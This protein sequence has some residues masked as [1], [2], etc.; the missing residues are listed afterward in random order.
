[1]IFMMNGNRTS[2]SLKS[3]LQINIKGDLHKEKS[4]HNEY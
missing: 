4:S 2:N 3:S 1:M